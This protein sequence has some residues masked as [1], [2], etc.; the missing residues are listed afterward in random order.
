MSFEK[1]ASYL[2]PFYAI[3]FAEFMACDNFKNKLKSDEI[4]N[5]LADNVNNLMQS[6]NMIRS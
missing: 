6:Q 5:W 2:L 3:E 4:K 1:Y